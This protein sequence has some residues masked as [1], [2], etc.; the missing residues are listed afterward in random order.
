MVRQIPPL[1]SAMRY[2]FS[3]VRRIVITAL[4]STDCLRLTMA[5]EFN[6]PYC[7]ATIRVPDAYAGQ[8]GRCPKCD[9]KLLV[10]NPPK[11]GATNPVSA[12]DAVTGF[13][14]AP[15]PQLPGAISAANDEL[16]PALIVTDSPGVRTGA[17][18]SG[19]RRRPK[20][21]MLAR[22][23]MIGIPVA[24]FLLL[25]AT[26]FWSLTDAL[27][28]TGELTARRLSGAALPAVTLPWTDIELADSDRDELK[29]FLMNNP[30]VLSSDLLTCRLTGTE[31]GIEVRLTAGREGQWFV[32]ESASNGPLAQWQKKERPRLNPLRLKVLRSTLAAWAKDKLIQSRG[33]RIAIDAAA[34]RDNIGLNAGG[35][36]LSFVVAAVVGDLVIP[37]AAEDNDGN[38]I[39][40]LPKNTTAF[41]VVGRE[42]KGSGKLFNGEYT[43]S[44]SKE[45]ITIE[46]AS[47]PEPDS[48]DAAKDDPA[49]EGEQPADTD[50]EK[51]DT[52]DDEPKSDAMK[53]DQMKMDQ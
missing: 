41:R 26:I 17:G 31:D 40:S 53:M 28:L 38:L 33:E 32:V 52:K 50:D 19:V 44:V 11:P 21:R 6:C 14:T 25:L 37:A 30:E 42:L 10:P 8:Q 3:I 47:E 29:Q 35:D 22:V 20:N 15:P 49:M 43:I 45:V 48:G 13:P 1:T 7:T 9:T 51:P 4:F 34:V 24:G 16:S 18:R 36:V 12:P 27:D 39:F 46:D 2:R 5:I 23:L